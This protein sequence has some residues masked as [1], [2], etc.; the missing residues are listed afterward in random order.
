V[1]KRFLCVCEG[2]NVRSVGLAYVLKNG[3]GQDAVACGWRF[4][5]RETLTLLCEWADYVVVM[6]QK[7][8]S[9]I[10]ARFQAKLRVVDV[11]PDRFGSPF[12]PE[13]QE[14]LQAVAASWKERRF[15][16]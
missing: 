14:F 4:N 3:Y 2:G 10:D 8:A 7:F 11:G 9:K 5:S 15:A 16:L 12:A 6:E 1:R 13:L